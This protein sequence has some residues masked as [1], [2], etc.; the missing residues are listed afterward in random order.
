[1]PDGKA[2]RSLGQARDANGRYTTFDAAPGVQTVAVRI[3]DEGWVA[4]FYG[5]TAANGF[6]RSP[7]GTI[8]TVDVPA[9]TQT[10]LAGINDSGAV[11]GAYAAA[12]G[13][14]HG[15]LLE[16]GVLTVIDPPGL[17]GDPATGSTAAVDVNNQGQVVGFYTDASGTYHG[18]LYQHGEFT[19]IDPP[20][21]ADVPNFATTAPLGI[22]NRGQVVGQYV[23][24]ASVL[25]GYLW[26]P[27]RGFTTI[28]PPRIISFGSPV[29]GAGTVAAD[30]NDRDQILLPAPGTDFQGRAPSSMA[31]PDAAG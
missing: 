14:E 26:Q 25:H 20:G 7:D 31:A 28:D 4:G 30:I 27:G 29:S 5:T 3:N 22:N 1:V 19:T 16:H 2:A 10:E 23:D 18:Y 21:A 9:A 13:Q 24:A 17:P 12:D 15:F 11:V 8:T 6:L